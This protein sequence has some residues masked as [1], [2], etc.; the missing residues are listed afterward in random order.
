MV[1]RGLVARDN[2]GFGVG[3]AP[4]TGGG[5][6]S[7][8]DVEATGNGSGVLA[9]FGFGTDFAAG[10]IT[11][12]IA[13][14]NDADGLTAAAVGS[15]DLGGVE[16]NGNGGTG[17]TALAPGLTVTGCRAA[18]NLTGMVLTGEQVTLSGSSASGNG[19]PLGGGFD[20]AGFVLAGV[21]HVAADDTLAFGN[22]VGWLLPDLAAP[23][24]AVA[25]AAAP[26]GGRVAASR[27]RRSAGAAAGPADV[28]I[29]RSRIESNKVAS[30]QVTLDPGE[31][32]AVR[33]SDLVDNGPAGLELL[34]RRDRRR[35]HRLVGRALRTGPS[36]ETRAAPATRSTTGPPASP[37][38]SSTSP[39]PPPR[40]RRGRAPSPARSWRSPPWGRPVSPSSS[41][42]WHWRRGA[43]CG[44][45][46]VDHMAR[47]PEP[48]E[49]VSVPAVGAGGL[50]TLLLALAG[51][52]LW[53]MRRVR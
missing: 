32:L 4:S 41:C 17:I 29:V 3:V 2:G 12:C 42:F 47:L 50:P 49:S 48:V 19:P 43:S 34:S 7:L 27:L 8:T 51:A 39:S 35:P 31:R 16:A 9:G 36:R 20:G 14:D 46:R 22:D 45:E 6:F 21:G 40:R 23:A 28:R 38:P 33:C 11:D 53:V 18:D 26:G 44:A 1:G 25:G 5:D 37:E 15:L 52:G 13:G 10:S 24:P 30:M